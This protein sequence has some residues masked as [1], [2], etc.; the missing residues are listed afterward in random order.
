MAAPAAAAAPVP[1]AAGVVRPTV[2]GAVASRPASSV[3]ADVD[4]AQPMD[5]E[6]ILCQ[7]VVKPKKE[8]VAETAAQPASVAPKKKKKKTSYKNMMAGMMKSSPERDVEKET[9]ESI[10]KVTGGGAFSKIDKI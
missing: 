5:V 4:E 1:S 3:L 6:E 7:P 8:A 2:Q 9:K 10:H